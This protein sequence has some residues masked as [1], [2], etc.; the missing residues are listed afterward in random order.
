MG[1]DRLPLAL[2]LGLYGLATAILLYMCLAPSTS[3]P[4]SHLW[5]KAEHAIAWAVLAAV[6]LVLFPGQ[7]AAILVFTL[8]FGIAVEVLQGALPFGRDMDWKD[9]VADCVGVAAA[10]AVWFA[11]CRLRP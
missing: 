1:F 11:I 2:R 6:G 10:F 9:W 7:P 8:T 4:N 5:D 3:L